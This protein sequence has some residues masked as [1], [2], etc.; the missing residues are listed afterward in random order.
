MS[1][2]FGESGDTQQAQEGVIDKEQAQSG[3]PGLDQ[4]LGQGLPT[5]NVFLLS[6]VMGNNLSLFAQQIM[7]KRIISKTK[8]AYYTVEQST[9]DI[10]NE[11]KLYGMNI[12]QFV[13]DGS[14]IFGRALPIDLKKITDALPEVPMEQRISLTDSLSPLM[15]HFQE[16][17][18]EGCSTVMHL[19]SLMR[20]FSIDEISNLLFFMTGVAREYGGIHFV[21]IT[22]DAHNPKDVVTVKDLADSVFDFTSDNRGSAITMTLTIQKIKDVFPKTRILRFTVKN[23]GL[24]TETIRRIK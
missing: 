7:Y 10:V 20:N 6:G 18:K 19:S 15:K 1:S 17:V 23:E 22:E 16:R 24:V 21:I 11:M 5:R 4:A 14:W 12:S 9:S 3:I 8:V 13:D 2:T